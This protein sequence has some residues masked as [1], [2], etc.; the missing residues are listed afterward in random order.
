MG[1]WDIFCAICG[2]PFSGC[3]YEQENFDEQPKDV[4][5]SLRILRHE[6][7]A[8]VKKF[9]CIGENSESESIDKYF[10]LFLFFLFFFSVTVL[11][12]A[13]CLFLDQQH[14]GIMEDAT[15]SHPTK[16]HQRQMNSRILFRCKFLKSSENEKKK[17][18]SNPS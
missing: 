14:T 7:T 17:K 12:H 15:W 10:S 8:W 5:Q 11:I 18:K 16:S 1:G 4:Q 13:E 6:D 3:E 9:R 2:G